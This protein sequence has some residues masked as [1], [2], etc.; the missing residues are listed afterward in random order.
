MCIFN[1]AERE[2]KERAKR[3]Y[4]E[5]I[6]LHPSTPLL[7]LQPPLRSE[8]ISVLSKSLLVAVQNPAI[9]RE[10]RAAGEEVPVQLGAL[11]RDQPADIETHGGADAHGLL[12]TGL[13]IGEFLGLGPGDVAVGGD[14]AVLDGVL[15]LSDEVLVHG[16][17][18]E[19]LPEERLH[20]GSGR[21]GAGKA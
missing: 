7:I 12:E 9:D 20:C 1:N 4:L 17:G 2:K 3:T 18:V 14:H 5:H 11:G 8:I 21:I 19:D 13:E 6:P 16:A 15:D 10:A